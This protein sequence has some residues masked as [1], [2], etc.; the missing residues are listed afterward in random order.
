MKTRFFESHKLFIA[1]LALVFLQSCTTTSMLEEGKDAAVP[2]SGI[3][4]L[5]LLNQQE[6]AELTLVVEI[7]SLLQKRKTEEYENAEFKYEDRQG[8]QHSFQAKVKPRGRFRRMTCEFPPLKLKFSKE[9]LASAGLTEMNELK[10]VTHCLDDK[11]I[12]RDMVLREYL[13]Y[14]L[15]NELTPNSLRVQ[16][17]KITYQDKSNPETRITRFGFLIED[18]EEIT[19]RT[20]TQ[21]VEKM[22]YKASQLSAS[23]E[24]IASLFQYMIGNTDWSIE[25]LRNVE[26][27]QKTDGRLIAV[28]YDFDFSGLVSAPYARPNVDVGQKKVGERVFMGNAANADELYSTLNYFLTK[29]DDLLEIVENFDL[30]DDLSKESIIAYLNEFFEEIKTKEKAQQ[31][32]FKPRNKQSGTVFQ[33]EV[34][35]P[36]A[37]N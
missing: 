14:K 21:I 33:N 29:Q 3:S 22:G 26:L 24:R 34:S 7:D 2:H 10:L 27:V 1:I 25:L 30:L 32:V 20:G 12:S 13:A 11:M 19:D 17:A 9:E 28:P 15:Y 36:Q 5:S 16:L 4:L 18:E 37:S 23:H 8:G 35:T 31:H 6:V